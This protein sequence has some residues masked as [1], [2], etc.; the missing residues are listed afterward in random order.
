MVDSYFEDNPFEYERKKTDYFGLSIAVI[1][2]L[3]LL[4][5]GL[6]YI[7]DPFITPTSQRLTPNYDRLNDSEASPGGAIVNESSLRP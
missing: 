2:V 6:V 1:A 7:F 4:S 5:G 3:F